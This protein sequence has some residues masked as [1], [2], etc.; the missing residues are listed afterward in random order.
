MSVQPCLSADKREL[1]PK[2]LSLYAVAEHFYLLLPTKLECLQTPTP[3]TSWHKGEKNQQEID[4]E[5][6]G[7]GEE[8]IH[9]NKS[10]PM[11]QNSQ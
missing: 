5:M 2:D 1:D 6:D 4:R 11:E 9:R 10:G 8:E 3:C 7:N